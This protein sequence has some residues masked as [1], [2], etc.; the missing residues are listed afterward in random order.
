[1]EA[2]ASEAQIEVGLPEME[3]N[4]KGERKSISGGASLD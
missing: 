2:V 4:A 3:A 1:M